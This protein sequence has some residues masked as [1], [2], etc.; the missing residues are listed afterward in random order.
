[1]KGEITMKYYVTVV[2][3]EVT[4]AAFAYEN[5]AQAMAKFHTEMRYAYDA[6]I[7]TLCS[8]MSSYG[9]V[10]AVEKYTAPSSTPES[11]EDV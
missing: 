10:A 8:V 4:C 7:T 2:Q 11:G 3:G 9:A 6:G 1:M 5:K